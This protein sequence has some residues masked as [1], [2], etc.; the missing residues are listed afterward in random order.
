MLAVAGLFASAASARDG[1]D[2]QSSPAMTRLAE[3]SAQRVLLADTVAASKRESGKPVEDAAREQSQLELLG[4]RATALGLAREQATAFFKAQ[5]EANKLVQYR[6]LAQPSRRRGAAQAVDLDAVRK[7]LD[8]INA[9]LLDTLAP[10]WSE[11]RG[12]GCTLRAQE[13]QQRA[14]RRHRLDELHRVALARAFGDLCR[15]P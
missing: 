13:A 11:A 9:E 5:I 1:A 6:L 8:G 15:M 12:A 4:A 14:A 10:A 7:R 2:A 3:L